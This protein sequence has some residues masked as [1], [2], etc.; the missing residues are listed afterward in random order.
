M[1]NAALCTNKLD[2]P[3]LDHLQTAVYQL[4]HLWD[5]EGKDIDL[6]DANCLETVTLVKQFLYNLGRV[7]PVV[8]KV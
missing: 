6:L 3:D 4:M 1:M 2:A 5:L 8:F 7:N